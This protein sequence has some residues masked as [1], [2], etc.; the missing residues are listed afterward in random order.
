MVKKAVKK[1]LVVAPP[2]PIGKAAI[3]RNLRKLERGKKKVTINDPE[4]P[5]PS[6]GSSSWEGLTDKQRLKAIWKT[7]GLDS[8][9]VMAKHF[10]VPSATFM[11]W[12]TK[13]VT[14]EDA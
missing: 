4:I 9:L 3:D 14:R 5:P 11:K 6:R 10:G 7:E 13:W 1:K 12:A 2:R 8:G